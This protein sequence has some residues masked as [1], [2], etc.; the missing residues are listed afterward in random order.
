MWSLNIDITNHTVYLIWNI[1]DLCLIIRYMNRLYGKPIN[2][3]KTFFI[4]TILIVSITTVVMNP[5][6]NYVNIMAITSMSFI[7][8]V[9][10]S[11]NIQKKIL[12]S[13]INLAIAGFGTSISYIGFSVLFDMESASGIFDV[14]ITHFIFWLLLEL[15]PHLNKDNQSP[16]PYRLWLLFLAIPIASIFV[17]RCIVS[18]F[19]SSNLPS[20]Q[21]AVLGLPILFLLLSINLMVFFLFS[22]FSDLVSTSAE[23]T[24]LAQQVRFQ[25]QHYE[26][27]DEVHNRIRS[28]RHDVQNSLQ[29]LSFLLGRGEMHDLKEYMEALTESI[30]DVDQVIS[31]KNPALDSVLSIKIS[32]MQENYIDIQ[33]EIRIPQGLKISFEQSVSLIGNIMDNALEACTALVQEERK[34]WLKI[35][36]TPE[37]LFISLRNTF[38]Q[39]PKM[40][41]KDFV[42][43][44]DEALLHGLGLKNVRRVVEE[45]HGMMDIKIEGN[46]F[47]IKIILYGI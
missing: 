11:H 10:Y 18:V 14:I 40:Y 28:I 39:T 46:E 34:V 3:R 1:L 41:K 20:K 36:Y 8:L 27:L 5:M 4:V 26:K 9:F 2:N 45:F 42:S 12:F 17:L 30:A 38:S 21:T 15:P 23:N 44:K 31:T 47:N 29:T 13:T 32:E 24:L 43:T 6:E 19:S 16:I 22:R 7:L 35:S 25:K 37:I 33:T